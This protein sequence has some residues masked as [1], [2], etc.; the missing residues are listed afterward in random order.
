MTYTT[1]DT[2][3]KAVEAFQQFDVDTQLGLLWFGYKDIKDQ[4]QPANETS[5]QDTAEALFNQIQ[6]LSQ[7]EQLQAQ[8]DIVSRANSDISRAYTSLSSSGKLDVWLRLAQGMDKGTV[9]QVPSDYELPAETKDFANMVK[10]LDF[11]QRI[12]FMRS[13]V[14]EMG[15]K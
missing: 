14:V 8:R 7:E 11:E 5:A 9:I 3:K 13:A 6:S 2:T 1:D 10:Q 4:L 12:D 15:A